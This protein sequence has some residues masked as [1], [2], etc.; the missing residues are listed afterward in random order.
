MTLRVALAQI[1]TTVGDVKGNKEK[2]LKNILA[3]KESAADIVVFPELAISGYP[4]EDLL[5]KPQFLE[6]VKI[7]LD[8]VADR[9][10]GIC[11][12]VGFPESAD[13][14]YNSA[15]VCVEGKIEG[16]YRKTHLPNYGVFDESRYFMAGYEPM[17]IQLGQWRIGLTICE[18]IWLPG[19]PESQ[20]VLIGGARCII[21]ISASPFFAGK[22]V[23]RNRMLTTRADDLATYVCY[24]NLVG[25]QDE[26]VFDG[27]SLVSDYQGNIIARAR[28]FEEDLLIA[29][30]DLSAA[31]RDRLHDPRF[32][33]E[34]LKARNKGESIRILNGYSSWEKKVRPQIKNRLEK[35]PS[36]IEEVYKAL[37][38]GCGDYVKKNCFQKVILGLSGGV[39]SAISAVI[40]ADALGPKNVITLSMPGKY[41]SRGSKD[42]AYALAKNMGFECIT[43]PIEDVFDSYLDTLEPFFKSGKTDVTQENIQARIRGNFL[44]AFSNKFGYMVLTTGNKSEN[45]VGYATLYGDMAG[46]FNIIKDVPKTL[47]Y[48]L[49]EYRNSLGDAPV[50]PKNI[51]TKPPSA[52]LRPDQ[53]DSDSLPQY[54]ILD[55]ILEMYVEKDFSFDRMVKAGNDPKLLSRIIGLVDKSEYKRRQSSP[56]IKITPR[57]F[58]K[59][60]RLPI[61]NRYRD[62]KQN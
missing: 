54:D 57:A 60:R 8:Q 15:A 53:K 21:N 23:S 35:Q 3:A 29:D 28:A 27:N 36:G 16:I 56:G 38:L 17:V 61:T 30:I 44:M 9:T 52:E 20:E 26:L 13:D 32:R 33:A 43:V 6:A 1:N 11:A 50:I 42:D 18:D 59:D 22:A 49:C 48:K 58:G 2:I 37:V 34:K 62:G 40:A 41:S 14:V 51:I 12:I 39:D 25:G 45:S 55:P 47:V 7:A 19:A 31:K 46:G 5:L 10:R 4:A 24:C